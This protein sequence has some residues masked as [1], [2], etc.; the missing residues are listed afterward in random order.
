MHENG[1]PDKLT[2]LIKEPWLRQ[3][4]GLSCAL[5]NIGLEGVVRRASIDTSGSIFNITVQLLAYADDIDIIARIPETVKD[6]YIRLRAEQ[7]GLDWQCDENKVYESQ[8]L[9]ERRPPVSHL[10][11]CGW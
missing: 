9:Q 1:F 11:S 7:D 10:S 3:G 5:F 4:D 2:W 6:V 8:G